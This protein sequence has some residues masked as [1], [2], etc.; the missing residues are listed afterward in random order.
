[1]VTNLVVGPG[2]LLVGMM[3]IVSFAG[4][5]GLPVNTAAYR[6][7]AQVFGLETRSAISKCRTQNY[8]NCDWICEKGPYPAFL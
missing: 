1:M 4:T 7:K 3:A 2:R 6:M 5:G 8:H